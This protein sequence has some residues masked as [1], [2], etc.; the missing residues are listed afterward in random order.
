MNVAVSPDPQYFDRLESLYR[1]RDDVAVLRLIAAGFVTDPAALD[2]TD[3][4]LCGE[5]DPALE[6]FALLVE[7]RML[8][9]QE[10]ERPRADALQFFP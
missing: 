8:L 6:P 7:L 4:V 2:E 3:L 10:L 5:R 9:E 1:D